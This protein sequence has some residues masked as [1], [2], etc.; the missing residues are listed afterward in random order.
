M[1]L[2]KKLTKDYK[3]LIFWGLQKEKND[4]LKI[5]EFVGDRAFLIPEVNLKYLGALAE[6]CS[7]FV[8][9]DTGP[10][11]IAWSLG[12]N[13]AAIFGP[14]NPDLQG[15]LNGNS[16]IIRN[17]ALS[18]LGCGLTQIADCPNEHKCMR[19][20]SVDEVY[21]QVKKLA[22]SKVLTS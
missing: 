11:H 9:N 3:I 17:E 1:E 4:A 5:K 14:T 2:A 12:V 22:E 20:L 6:K 15:P 7:V 8:T 21:L 18:C 19:D 16:V 10:M 13:T